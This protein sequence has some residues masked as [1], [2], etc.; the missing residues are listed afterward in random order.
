MPRGD[1]RVTDA[2]LPAAL[3]DPRRGDDQRFGHFRRPVG[4][5]GERPAVISGHPAVITGFSPAMVLAEFAEF[6]EAG[7]YPLQFLPLAYQTLGVTD[8]SRV[9]HLCSGSVRVGVTV[10]IR[11]DAGPSVVA[12]C[13]S[14]PFA[15]E[16]FD[17]VM[18][19]P[20]YS[21]RW[22][23][24]LYGLTKRNYPTPVA[25]TREAA[26]VLR[27][28]GRVGILHYQMA[29]A[30]GFRGRGR[31]GTLRL[32]GVWGLVLGPGTQIRAW[33]VYEKP[34]P[35]LELAGGGW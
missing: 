21:R 28:G 34:A 13:R 3:L 20:P 7:G 10:D 9:L 26:R 24:Q 18:A 6:P 32:V 19:D 31:T 11:R 16:S 33:T 8:P 12:D 17:W 15:D 22:A 25:I 14:L 1:E 30:P 2:S 29:P 27:P 5:R 4:R 35:Q 23:R